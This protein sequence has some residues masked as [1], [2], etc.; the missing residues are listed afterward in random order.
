MKLN[1]YKILVMGDT[2]GNL[3]LFNFDKQS[4]ASAILPYQIY[5]VH[6]HERVISI[7]SDPVK[8]TLYSTSKDNFIKE[9]QFIDQDDLGSVSSQSSL[10]D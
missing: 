5:K 3:L 10:I 8:N 7:F 1:D 4:E 6:K 9:Y 2:K